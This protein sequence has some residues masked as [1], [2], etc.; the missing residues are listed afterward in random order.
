MYALEVSSRFHNKISHFV[1]LIAHFM[2]DPWLTVLSHMI[3]CYVSTIEDLQKPQEKLIDYFLW[4]PLYMITLV[5]VFPIG[6][7]GILL[8][9]LLCLICDQEKCTYAKVIVPADNKDSDEKPLAFTLKT[10]TFTFA[11]ANVLLAPEFLSRMNNLKSVYKR[12]YKIAK[13]FVDNTG[14]PLSNVK[15]FIDDTCEIS[16]KFKSVQPKFPN[17]DFLCLQEVWTRSS[18]MILVDQLQQEFSYFLFDVGEFSPST[19][20]CMLGS[21]LMFASKRP[22]LEADF[23]TFTY[24]VAH[25]QYTSQGVLCIKVLLYHE[26]LFRHVGFVTNLHTQAF[27]GKEPVIMSQLTEVNLFLNIFKKK[28]TQKTD[29]VEFDVICGD[30]NADNMSPADDDVQ[31]HVLLME[32]RDVCVARPGEDRHWAIGTELR[33]WALCDPLFEDPEQFCEALVD[34]CERRLYVLDADVVVHNRELVTKLVKPDADGYVPEKRYGG[35]RRID[36]ILYKRLPRTE[37][38]GYSFV[39]SLGNLTDHIPV[40]MTLQTRGCGELAK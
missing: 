11:T 15:L 16:S 12:A 38:T 5:C 31:T 2:M 9:C 27:Q 35:M 18:A 14:K 24:R 25:A 20:Y 33:Q 40:C 19:N 13:H 8:W 22:I 34:D 7:V 32:Y 23:K 21:G 4:G 17:I 30:F 10:N 39:T 29:I 1:D 26:G 3:A 37:V 28:H 6:I 36:R